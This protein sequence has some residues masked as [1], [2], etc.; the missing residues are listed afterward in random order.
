MSVKSRAGGTLVLMLCIVGAIYG[1]RI[2][3]GWHSS[4]ESLVADNEGRSVPAT[5]ALQ[6]AAQSAEEVFDAAVNALEARRDTAQTP[7]SKEG[8]RVAP[9]SPCEWH[10]S[11][12]VSRVD[13]ADEFLMGSISHALLMRH[14]TLNPRDRPLCPD[15]EKALAKVVEQYNRFIGPALS[16]FRD[17]RTQ[18]VSSL[19]EAGAIPHWSSGAASD[20]EVARA[21]ATLQRM[22]MNADDARQQ[23]ERSRHRLNTPPGNYTRNGG[24][25]YI[26]PTPAALPQYAAYYDRLKFLIVEQMQTVVAWF[27][28]NGFVVDP[29]KLA[30]LYSQVSSRRI[31]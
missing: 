1:L 30:P 8:V 6:Q 10:A 27:V 19:I 4:R 9:P 23:A 31:E 20:A 25:Y 28:A 22:G 13:L 14:E 15:E 11:V 26:L 12:H 7:Q 2:S 21:A 3:L 24:R 5:V 17:L 29:A 16:A 18:E